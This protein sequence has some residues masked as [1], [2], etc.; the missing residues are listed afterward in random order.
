MAEK[1]VRIKVTSVEVGF[2][3]MPQYLARS[4]EKISDYFD[5]NIGWE[6]IRMQMDCT[7]YEIVK[8]HE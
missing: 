1:I 6:E 3:E 7:T 5:S 4:E 2:F 8:E